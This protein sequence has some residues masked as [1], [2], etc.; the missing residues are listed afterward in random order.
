[1]SLAF[2]ASDAR[3]STFDFLPSTFDVSFDFLPSTS[4]LPLV[5]LLRANGKAFDVAAVLFDK[6]G[7]LVD[8]DISWARPAIRWIE[9]A[10]DGGRD[11]AGV[12]ADRLG[13]DA[14]SGRLVPDGVLAAGTVDELERHT[15][16]ILMEAGISEGVADVRLDSAR[17]MALEAVLDS[18]NMPLLGDVA[19]GFQR[20]ASANVGIGVVTSD[21]RA[22]AVSLLTTVGVLDLVGG[23]VGGDDGLSPKPAPDGI[24]H[25]CS[26]LEVSPADSLMVGDSTADLLAA[27]AARMAGF[28][29]VGASSPAAQHADAVISSIDELLVEE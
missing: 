17:R 4:Y 1:M 24:L 22:V 15:R 12:L 7:T 5:P 26:L 10:A 20:L 19:A 23:L 9:Q 16:M 8:L 11:L 21:D 3:P 25:V 14:A 18:E 28:V 6:D 13:F 27:R 29:A 2:G